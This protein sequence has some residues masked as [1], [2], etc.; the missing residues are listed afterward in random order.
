VN[1]TVLQCLGLSWQQISKLGVK[2]SVPAGNKNLEVD[3]MKFSRAGVN[4]ILSAG[5]ELV[6]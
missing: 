1:F 6:C 5:C 2:F 3:G 4:F